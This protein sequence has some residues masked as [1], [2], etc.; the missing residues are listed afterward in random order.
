MHA[1]VPAGKQRLSRE[2]WLDFGLTVLRDEGPQALKAEPLCKRLGV[3]R[4]S[5]YWHFDSAGVFMLAVVERWEAR[6]TEQVILAVGQC[7]GGTAEKLRFLLRK[8]GELDVRLYEAIHGLEARL[9]ELAGVLRR[10]HERRLGFLA[11]L[12][13][14]Q[15]L[16]PDE[17]ALRA[18][19]TY[20]WAMGELLTRDPRQQAYTEAQIAAV[21][22]L[23]LRP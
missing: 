15:G 11:D 12:L 3:S 22:R 13:A 21:E 18:R 20:A 16:A 4:G 1:Q 19:M 8:V 10:V 9:P 2:D 14:A 5:F 23:L 17:A 6:A 7:V